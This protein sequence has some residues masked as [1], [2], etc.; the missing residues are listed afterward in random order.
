MH[1]DFRIKN[2]IDNLH[3]RLFVATVTT[4]PALSWSSQN[5]LNSYWRFYCNSSE[6]AFLRLDSHLYPLSANRIYFIPAGV[7]FGCYNPEAVRHFYIH[8]D[9]IGLSAWVQREI[10]STLLAVPVNEALQSVARQLSIVV[11]QEDE[12]NLA[13]QCRL[14]SLVYQALALYLETLSPETLH[15][16]AQIAT[17]QGALLPALQ[18]IEQ[19]VARPVTNAEL[20]ALCHLSEDYFI[21]RFRDSIGQSPLQYI[22]ERRVTL[23]AQRLLFG[24]ESIEEI[25]VGTG[26]ANRFHFSRVFTRKTGISP[27]AYRKQSRV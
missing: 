2:V 17:A 14:K 23:A 1:H 7:R 9:V 20:A 4:L 25:S 19:D 18:R 16:C 26:F 12:T 5:L 24:E 27:A 21:R 22:L 15:R 11:E 13:L 3:V 6:G 8:F 10:F